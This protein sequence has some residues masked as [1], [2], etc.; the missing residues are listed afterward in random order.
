MNIE[1]SRIVSKQTRWKVKQQFR[2][3]EGRKVKEEES[4][5]GNV[6]EVS[7]SKIITHVKGNDVTLV[8]MTFCSRLDPYTESIPKGWRVKEEESR[9]GIV[10][11]VRISK[12]RILLTFLTD[13]ESVATRDFQDGEI[14]RKNQN[15]KDQIYNSR[16]KEH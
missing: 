8:C 15:Q 12:F 3:P 14:K 1:V 5:S 10:L 16:I 2:L 13:W 6:L 11:K 4:Q 7:I 9:F